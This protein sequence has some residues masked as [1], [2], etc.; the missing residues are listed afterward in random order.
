MIRR[1]SR[2]MKVVTLTEAKGIVRVELLKE[3]VE[4]SCETKIQTFV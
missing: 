2:T 3:Q 4:T 1:S